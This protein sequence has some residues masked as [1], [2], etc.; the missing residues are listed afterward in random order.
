MAVCIMTFCCCCC[1]FCGVGGGEVR[2]WS[3]QQ[4]VLNHHRSRKC[5]QHSK[6]VDVKRGMMNTNGVE[7]VVW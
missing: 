1:C 3:S 2:C 6:D 7:K 4:M 5:M